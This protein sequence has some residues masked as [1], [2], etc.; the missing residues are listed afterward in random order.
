M[1]QRNHPNPATFARSAY[2]N[3]ID[4]FTPPTGVRY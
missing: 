3:A 1:S 4:S 2:L